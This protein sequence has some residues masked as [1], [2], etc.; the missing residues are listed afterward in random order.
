[1]DQQEL[2][3]IYNKLRQKLL[4]EAHRRDYLPEYAYDNE[5][6]REI[7]EGFSF[8]HYTFS[9][10][11]SRMFDTIIRG[12]LDALKELLYDTKLFDELL[13]EIFGTVTQ[14][15]LELQLELEGESEREAA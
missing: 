10:R 8:G 7:P 14:A 6:R 3:I 4:E 9:I 5:S 2:P 1:M 15:A 12:N 13:E 11:G